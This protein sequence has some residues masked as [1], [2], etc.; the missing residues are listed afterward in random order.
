MYVDYWFLVL[1]GSLYLVFVVRS[2]FVGKWVYFFSSRLL[3]VR[4][5]NR[6]HIRSVIIKYEQRN[7]I[8]K[9]C[10]KESV[11][12]ICMGVY[13]VR[14]KNMTGYTCAVEPL[15]ASTHSGSMLTG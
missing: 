11:P 1:T 14:L 12:L 9:C 5:L 6:Q 8:V 4:F 13:I 2:R 3:I 15:C 10:M 7:R